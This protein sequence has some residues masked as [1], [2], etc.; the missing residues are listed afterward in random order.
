MLTCFSLSLLFVSSLRLIQADVLPSLCDSYDG[1]PFVHHDSTFRRT[2]NVEELF[3]GRAGEDVS[4]FN[5]TDIQKLDAG[6]WFLDVSGGVLVCILFPGCDTSQL[7]VIGKSR[8]L[9]WFQGSC[10]IVSSRLEWKQK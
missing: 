2:T 8:E 1:V 3:P 6:S 5:M 4:L 9:T 7:T 10:F